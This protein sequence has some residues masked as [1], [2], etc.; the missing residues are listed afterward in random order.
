MNETKL[1]MKIMYHNGCTT[2]ESC[3]RNVIYRLLGVILARSGGEFLDHVSSSNA[4]NVQRTSHVRST[5]RTF[6]KH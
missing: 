1:E 4:L 2:N 5:K 3:L 6:N